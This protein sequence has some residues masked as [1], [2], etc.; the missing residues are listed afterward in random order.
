MKR[1]VNLKSRGP[2]DPRGK[3]LLLRAFSGAA[4]TVAS[5]AGG[6]RR[7]TGTEGETDH[8]GSS[9]EDDDF[10]NLVHIQD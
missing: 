2:E 1:S 9:D 4:G 3:R 8:G 6:G 7:G 5:A 10:G